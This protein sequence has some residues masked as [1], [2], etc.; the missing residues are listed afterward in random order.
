M[1]IFDFSAIDADPTL[2]ERLR[3]G[4]ARIESDMRHDWGREIPVSILNRYDTERVRYYSF[5]TDEMVDVIRRL[6]RVIWPAA[7]E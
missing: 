6:R 1:P 2:G 3:E 7:Q 5:P 4:L